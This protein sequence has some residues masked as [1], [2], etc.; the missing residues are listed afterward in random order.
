VRNLKTI[1]SSS[2]T[3]AVLH[4]APTGAKPS[5]F[6]RN[7]NEISAWT[8]RNPTFVANAATNLVAI[9]ESFASRMIATIPF[10]VAFVDGC[11]AVIQTIFLTNLTIV[12]SDRI[13]S[14]S[15]GS[16]EAPTC[17]TMQSIA[18][19]VFVHGD[20]EAF[21]VH[22]MQSERPGN[23]LVSYRMFSF[24]SN[25]VK[26]PQGATKTIVWLENWYGGQNDLGPVIEFYR[27]NNPYQ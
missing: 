10:A 17:E 12:R 9:V 2:A 27:A 11:R 7:A 16:P 22:C 3:S 25:P 18:R 26:T 4:T 6:A 19:S 13:P 24:S 14:L 1:I 23:R 21:V 8:A 20:N 5:S 15:F